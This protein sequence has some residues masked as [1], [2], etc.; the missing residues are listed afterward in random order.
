MKHT[1][2]KCYIFRNIT[3][4]NNAFQDSDDKLHNKL[5]ESESKKQ[6]INEGIERTKAL[7]RKNFP[8]EKKKQSNR[9]P[10]VWIYNR[11]LPNVKREI[12]YE[13]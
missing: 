10:F 13:M 4:T 9:I 11:V 3:A 5:I 8:K 7:G 12:T 1:I 2:C 6:E